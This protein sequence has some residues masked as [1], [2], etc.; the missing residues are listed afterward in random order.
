[1]SADE[2][3]LLEEHF[4]SLLAACDDALA[5][6]NSSLS[7]TGAEV[8]PG[9]RPRL[10]GNLACMQ[11]LQKLRPRRW[12]WTMATPFGLAISPCCS[13]GLSTLKP[14]L[15]PEAEA[16][17]TIG[18]FQIRRELGRGGFGVVFLAYDPR[19][20]REVALKVPRADALISP[21]LRERFHREARAA[22]GLDHPNLVAVYE[23]GEI[24]PICY[25]AE[26]YCPGITLAAWLKQR[27]ELMP[28]RE[29]A[30]LVAAL[31]EAVQHAH[32]RGVLHRDLKPRNILLTVAKGPCRGVRE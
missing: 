23:A 29:A 30:L 6:G 14:G 21:G 7:L 26:A 1:M 27:S 32:S 11:R 10:E 12:P 9:L 25:I 28:A 16:A 15:E 3:P 5:G 17:K 18:R 2:S 31:A 20:D 22:A 13:P 19:L 24:G 4:T 8:P